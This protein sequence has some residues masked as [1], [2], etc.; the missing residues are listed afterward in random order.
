MWGQ[1]NSDSSLFMFR[2]EANTLNMYH[3]SGPWPWDTQL[4][5]TQHYIGCI[6]D[7]KSLIIEMRFD[8]F[9]A[10]LQL[11]FDIEIFKS[12]V[13]FVIFNNNLRTTAEVVAADKTSSC[14]WSINYQQ[15]KTNKVLLVLYCIFNFQLNS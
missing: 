4:S 2:V 5:Q 3:N 12:E 10:N 14:N 8:W 1:V 6:V 11:F 7:C 13:G 15:N 9:Y